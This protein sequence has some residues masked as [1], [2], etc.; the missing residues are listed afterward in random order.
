MTETEAWVGIDVAKAHLDVAV[1]PAD[2]AWRVPNEPAGLAGLAERLRE[3]GPTL[4]V[5]EATGGLEAPVAAALGAA[6]LP[7]AVVNPRQ[8]RQFAQATGRLAK[9]DALDARVLAHF[10]EAVRPEPRPLP[11]AATRELGDLVGRRRQLVE[12]LVAERNRRRTV[13]G[14]VGERIQAHIAFLERELDDLDRALGDAVRASPAWRAADDLL[15][16]VPGI[17]PVTAQALLAELPELG[18]LDRRRI[19]ALVGVAPLNRDSGTLRG[20]RTCWGGRAPV[21]AALDMAAR[22]AA[23]FN[24]VIRPFYLRLRA[25]GKADKVALVACMRKLL[26][27]LNAVLRDQLPW[28]PAP[29]S[30]AATP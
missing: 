29:A 5:L 17:S 22:S 19:A 26:V 6:G 20:P 28:Q 23:R 4:V 18:H 21:R 10:A 25:A 12:M 14:R 30:T 7:V 15:R 27:I 11:D 2:A 3:V 16:G 9:T 1:R 8:V 13:G 24:P